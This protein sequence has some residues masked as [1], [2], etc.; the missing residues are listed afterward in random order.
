MFQDEDGI[1]KDPDHQKTEE[2]KP[3]IG[4][5]LQFLHSCPLTKF[6]HH[7]KN[8]HGEFTKLLK[9]LKI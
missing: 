5:R 4:H 3:K 6:L 8:E 9:A 7:S 2:H 1:E